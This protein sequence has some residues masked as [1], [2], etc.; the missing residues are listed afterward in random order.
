MDLF[1]MLSPRKKKIAKL[2][3]SGKEQE[4]KQDLETAYESYYQAAEL[5]STEAM[6]AIASLYYAKMFRPLEQSNFI[7][8]FTQ[9]IPAFPWNTV[10]QKVPDMKSSLEWFR[11]AADAGD[12]KGC[13]MAGVMLCEGIGRKADPA[14]GLPYLDKAIAA[15]YSDAAKYKYLYQPYERKVFSDAE[16][17]ELLTQFI[18]SAQTGE[19]ACYEMYAR[20]KGGSDQQLAR[21]GY[22]IVT[23]KNIHNAAFEPF[24]YSFSDKGIPLIPACAKRANWNTFIRFDLNAFASENTVIAFSSDIDPEHTLGYSHHLKRVGKASYRSPAFGWLGE[25]KEAIL[26]EINRQQALDAAT[27]LEVAA[28]Y[29]LI[30]EEYTGE[31]VAILTECGEKEYSVELAAITGGRVD[32]LFRYTIGGSDKIHN[33]FAPKLLSFTIEEE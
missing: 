9:G 24:K 5:G 20:L 31:D 15:G 19:D 17:E 32:V 1:A 12:G 22:A 30:P 33:A 3:S 14:E 23:A 4:Q 8:L 7:E 28:S 25:E 29:H 27:L 21:L 18:Q 10:T 6:L 2:L 11:K 16:Y 13:Y 26:F